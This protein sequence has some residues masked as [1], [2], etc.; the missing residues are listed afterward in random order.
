M[1]WAGIK[2]M[3]GPSYHL[4]AQQTNNAWFHDFEIEVDVLSQKNIGK[5]LSMIPFPLN[6]DGID[7]EGKNILIERVNITNYDDA[8]AVKPSANLGRCSE[9]IMIRDLNVWYS[10]GL[11]IGSVSANDD[12][13]CVRNVTFQDCK[14]YH[15]YKGIYVKTNPG[16][17]TSMLPGSGGEITDITYRNIEIHEP[18][19]WGIYIGPQQ[20]KQPGSH[21]GPGCMLYP[22]GG[23]ETQP[24]IAMNNITL[25][26]IRMYDAILPPGLI[27]CNET[28][29]CNGFIW[30]NVHAT[31]YK[32]WWEFL[33][34]GFISE[35]VHGVVTDSVPAP[36]LDGNVH[37]FKLSKFAKKFL[38][39]QAF[40]FVEH[41][42]CSHLSWLPCGDFSAEVDA[43]I[44]D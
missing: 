28:N 21:D 39:K 1:E 30:N 8:V 29:A 24:R 6:T 16:N 44:Q 37:H 18:I 10:V 23:C 11:T 14:M 2:L 9:N 25:D 42:I 20:Q 4:M 34:L 35:N 31:S 12:Y 7:P 19:W 33:G 40:K 36:H 13:K 27:R 38:K 5:V 32:G 41:F 22:L 43:L 3:N 15:P 17:T 26:N